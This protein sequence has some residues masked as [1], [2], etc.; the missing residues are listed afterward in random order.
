MVMNIVRKAGKLAFFVAAAI[1]WQLASLQAGIASGEFKAE[2]LVCRMEPGFDIESVNSAFG[3]T[4]KGFV[5][6]T[7]CYLLGTQAGQDAESLAVIIDQVEGVQYCGANYYLDAPEPLQRSQGF[8]DV[9]GIGD[10]ATQVAATALSLP[11]VHLLAEG[12]DVKVAVIDCGIN[13][14]H[15]EFAAGPGGVYSGWD[16]VDDDAVANDE[17]GGSGSGHGTF[18]AGVIRLVAPACDIYAYRVLDT[19]GRGDGYSVTTAL[20]QAIDDGCRVINLS[21]GMM[22]RHD[23]L[24]D[25]LNY[26]ESQHITVITSAGNDNTEIDLLFPFPGKRASCLT[27]AA[28]DSQNIKADFSNY[29][30]KVNLCAPGTQIYSPHLDSYYAW[31]D[32]TS[33]AAPFVTGLA[34]LLYSV[35]PLA[36]SEEVEC[37]IHETA[38][39]IDAL[40]PGLEGKLGSGVVDLVA[41]IEMISGP[42]SCGCSCGVWGDVDGDGFINP[43]DVMYLV[44]FVF[45]GLDDRAVQVN[46]PR[47]VGD[48]NADDKVNPVD[49]VDYINYV[50]KNQDGFCNDPC[51]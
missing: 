22:G 3:T 31:W 29:G 41:A 49:V 26:A 39:N 1:V 42:S 18:V 45:R 25:A 21:L 37:V 24:D 28:V 11:T 34:T 17:P 19:L 9:D 10:F 20:L 47:A 2:E 51:L 38:N 23:A 15:P 14:T 30:P 50:Y 13:L 32:G 16:Y 5:Q 43:V 46:C 7:G 40:N 48:V 33:F 6:Q 35:D 36:T 27:V 12:V 4:I 8:L 44:N